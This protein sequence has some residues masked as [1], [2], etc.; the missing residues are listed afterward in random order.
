MTNWQNN[1]KQKS[2]GAV[3]GMIPLVVYE[4]GDMTHAAGGQVKRRSV[5]RRRYSR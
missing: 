4:T 2:A 1:C 3:N 5:R